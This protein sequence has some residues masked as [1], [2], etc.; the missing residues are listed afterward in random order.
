MGEGEGVKTRVGVREGR[1]EGKEGIQRRREGG[2]RGA[3]VVVECECLT[4]EVPEAGH[5]VQDQD[6]DPQQP[7]YAPDVG[8]HSEPLDEFENATQPKKPR[9]LEEAKDVAI[10]VDAA[11]A[12]R[13]DQ[14]KGERGQDVDDE[15]G[16]QVIGLDLI[17]EREGDID[18]VLAS[19]CCRDRQ[20]CVCVCVLE[21]D[22]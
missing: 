21:T 11:A 5:P 16:P 13:G 9:E 10:P 12:D 2:V 15:P 6:D 20:L 4:D 22:R 14:L 19:V 1:G 7:Q 3:I 8:V 17:P 18:S